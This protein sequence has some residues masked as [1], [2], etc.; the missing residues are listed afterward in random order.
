MQGLAEEVGVSRATLFRRAGGREELLSKALW[1][2]TRR[3]L[4][5][6]AGRWEAQ[7]PPGTLHTPGTG[8]HFNAIVS[9]SYGLRRL[10]DDEPALAMRVLTDPR[11]RV[12]N[13]I[14]AFFEALLRRDIAEFGIEPVIEPGALAFALVRLG[15]AFVYADVLANRAPDVD[16]ADQLQLALLEGVCRPRLDAITTGIPLRA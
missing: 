6:A 14:V 15:E 3:T 11:G 10:L 12:Q 4:A 1:M 9:R 16:T 2:L 5:V 13:G 7:R 8:R